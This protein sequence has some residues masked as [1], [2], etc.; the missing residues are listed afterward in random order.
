MK[1]LTLSEA[2]RDLA[3]WLKQAIAGEEI[4]IRSGDTIVALRPLPSGG[5]LKNDSTHPREVLKQLQ[6]AAHLSPHQAQIYLHEIHAERLAAEKRP[7]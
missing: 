1:T 7:A 2:V 4:G 3:T 6:K 5:G